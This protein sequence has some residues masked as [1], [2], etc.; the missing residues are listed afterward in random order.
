VPEPP[1]VRLEVRE[2]RDQIV[3]V[4]EE[5]EWPLARTRWTPLY[6]S[7]DGQLRPDPPD[8]AG[9]VTFRVRREAATFTYSIREETELTGP[10]ALR[11]WLCVDGTDDVD[12]VVGV[13]KW[14]G[15]RYLGFEGSYGFGRDRVTTGWQRAS[16][17]E[18]DEPASTAAEPVHTY[19]RRQPLGPDEIV[20]VDVALGPSATRFRPGES[21]RLVIAGRWLWPRNPLTGNFP[22]RYSHTPS[23]RCTLHWG[24]DRRAR[25]LVPRIPLHQ[26]P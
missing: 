10:M 9:C 18:L 4:R 2:S 21:L 3:E 13:E 23:G 20:P 15:K 11:L 17:R 12:L 16:L 24:P 8:R 22:A 5:K 26:P 25:L 7:P 6:L 1:R 14:R 19:R